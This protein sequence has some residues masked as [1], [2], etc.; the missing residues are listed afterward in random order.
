MSSENAL[1]G[2]L[3]DI[4][5]LLIPVPT[6]PCVP[7]VDIKEEP[8]HYASGSEIATLNSLSRCSIAWAVR[9]LGCAITLQGAQRADNLCCE[10]AGTPLGRLQLLA[11]WT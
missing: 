5:S 2:R 3:S 4:A 9:T 10:P 1:R 6:A 11:V 8:G 7:L